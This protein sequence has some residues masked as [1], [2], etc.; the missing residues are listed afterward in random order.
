MTTLRRKALLLL[1]LALSLLLAL[2]PAMA[3]QWDIVSLGDALR[4]AQAAFNEADAAY[5]ELCETVFTLQEQ[6]D[7]GTEKE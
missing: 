7:N 6:Y 1:T 2:T 4:E 3:E 5:D